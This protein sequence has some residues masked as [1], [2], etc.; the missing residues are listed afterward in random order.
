MIKYFL[1]KIFTN[2]KGEALGLFIL[3]IGGLIVATLFVYNIGDF[4]VSWIKEQNAVDAASITA[5]AIQADALNAIIA[6]NYGLE[7]AYAALISTCWSC[8][9]CCDPHG[10]FCCCS[11]C[12]STSAAMKI[13][14][15]TAR[16]MQTLL[17]KGSQITATIYAIKNYKK[18][19][20]KGNILPKVSSLKLDPVIVMLPK[21][22]PWG[23]KKTYCGLVEKL[24]RNKYDWAGGKSKKPYIVG[25]YGGYYD[26]AGPG[27]SVIAYFKFNPITSWFTKKRIVLHSSA[28]PY[29]GNVHPLK[30]SFFGNI[31]PGGVPTFT[32]KIV[33][34][35]Y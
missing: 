2:E 16:G 1:K 31:F 29:G 32:A 10:C 9:A 21:T 25:S 27:V 5:A 28:R 11:V 15:K 23:W 30:V 19:G 33:P 20:G 6:E 14:E 7:T 34:S 18:S 8:C 3:V 12:G 13:I 4:F 26:K 22:Y 24:T 35:G 17:L